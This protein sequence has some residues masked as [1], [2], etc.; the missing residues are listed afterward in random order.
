MPR[1]ASDPNNIIRLCAEAH[2]L[3][4][5]GWIV[6]DHDGR[7]L[8]DHRLEESIAKDYRGKRL[9]GYTRANDRYM[10]DRR[11]MAIGSGFRSVA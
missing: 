7:C 6:F 10:A 8:V 11:A 9:T 2:R 4:D 5:G 1:Q 3:F